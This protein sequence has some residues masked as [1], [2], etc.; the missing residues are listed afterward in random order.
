MLFLQTYQSGTITPTEGVDGRFTL[1][2]EAGTGHTIYFSDRPDRLVGTN[3]TS[4]FLEG[5][6]FPDDN[7][8]NAALVVETAPGETD[9][10]VVELFNPL[11]DPVS[12]GV[13][14]EIEVLANWQTE[15][16][17][18]L[19]E[20][21]TDLATFLPTFGSAQLFIDDCPDM[22]MTCYTLDGRTPV[23][24]GTIDNSEHGGFCYSWGWAG[25]YPCTPWDPAEGVYAHWQNICNQRFPDCQGVCGVSKICSAG[26]DGSCDKLL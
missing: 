11:Y 7:P 1:S 16:E 6:G 25:C 20:E 9:I 8:P 5:L 18:G 26:I 4:D 21:P 22:T 3:P 12:Q 10:A 2:L 19:I 23:A 13:S 15:L 14:Y 17:M 24:H